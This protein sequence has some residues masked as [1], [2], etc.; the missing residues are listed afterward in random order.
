MD[1][2]TREFLQGKRFGLVGYSRSSQKFGNLVYAELKQ[3]GYSVLVVHPEIREI[4]GEK[5]VPHVGALAGRI[6]GL[7][8]NVLPAKSAQIVRDAAQAG[9]KKIWLQQGADSPEA[10]QAGR[11]LGVNLVAGKCILM[12]AEP[13]RSFHA[14][15]RLFAR[16]FGQM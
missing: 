3:R 2:S 13:V 15:H 9:I 10:V 8:V 5:C 4:G 6:D 1:S 16:L 11:E 7:I 12:Y 14:F